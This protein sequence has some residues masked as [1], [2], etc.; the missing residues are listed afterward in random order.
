VDQVVLGVIGGSG[1][2]D[3]ESLQDVQEM[4]VQTPFGDP[5]DT[6]T[7][8]TLSGLRV[9]FLPRHGRGHRISPSELNARAN[10]YALKS[11]GVEYVVSISACGS[12]REDFAPRDI[13]VPDQLFDRTKGIRSSTFFENGIV[14]H[15]GFET[16]YCPELSALVY[17]AVLKTGATVHKGGT[18]VVIEGPQFSTKAESRIYREWGVDLIGMTA[19]PEAKLAREA[20]LC[21]AALA[22]V[23]DYDVWHE[24]EEPV[25]VAMV[26][27]NLRANARVTKD[28]LTHLAPVLAG[29][30]GRT[31]SCASALENAIIT[32]RDMIPDSLKQKLTPLLGKYIGT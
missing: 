2:Y 27:D 20:E 29:K 4:H 8:G 16:P 11:L 22:H 7:I 9:G 24:T 32:Q 25:T 5:S 10:I 12:M 19:I 17:D 21:Y 14:V 6:I 31:C 18:M 3:L 26:L 23:T 13:V 1:V 15:V 30:R 28:A